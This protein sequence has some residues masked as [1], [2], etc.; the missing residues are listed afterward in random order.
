M[1]S[2]VLFVCITWCVLVLAVDADAL[3]CWPRMYLEVS[4]LDSWQRYR[5]EGYGCLVLPQC[6]G[7]N[8]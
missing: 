3:P 2:T 7:D 6:P 4:S 5:T 1:K 8:S